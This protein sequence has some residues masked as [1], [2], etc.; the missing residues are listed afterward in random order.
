[1]QVVGLGAGS[2]AKVVIEILR[3]RES[4]ELIGLLDPKPEL[5]GKSV[6]G[7]PV[8]GGD[9]L[10]AVL[11]RD[12]VCHF[13]VGLGSVGDTRPR[14][15]LFE[16][17]LEYGMRP[18]DAVHPQAVVSPSAEIGEGVTIMAGA[19][20]N[21]CAHLSV[22]VIVNTG[23]TVEHDCIIG[24]HVHIATGAQ[25]ASTVHVGNGTHVGAGATVL[26]CI[27]I[28]ENTLVGAGAVVIRDVPAG[29]TVVGCPA[30][31]LRRKEQRGEE[32]E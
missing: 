7:V 30:R 21:A 17:A 11:K 28:G 27:R 32:I 4:Y 31:I 13:F 5:H 19:V 2:H 24:D 9:D 3:C 6:L 14:R 25:L 15:R 22:N 18:V 12:G 16:L 1:V 20:I 8:L 23:A 10:L 29:V 26:Q